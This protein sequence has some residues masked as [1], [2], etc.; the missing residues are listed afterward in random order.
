MVRAPA[1]E[2][3]EPVPVILSLHRTGTSAAEHEITTR[4]ADRASA[5]GYLVISPD[6]G[7]DSATGVR[8]WNQFAATN[9]PDDDAF[10][11][12]A[13]D[14]VAARHCIDRARVFAAGHSSG[15]ALAGLFACRKTGVLQAVVM[16][17]AIAPAGCK[18]GNMP[19]VLAVVGDADPLV[20][21]DGGVAKASGLN[22]PPAFAL[23]ETWVTNGGC[24]PGSKVASAP[25]VLVEL[26]EGCRGGGTARFVTL[27]GGTHA[28]PGGTAVR[29]DEGTPSPLTT[30]DATGAALEL[31]GSS[32]R[33]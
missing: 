10:L 3:A 9:L 16:V 6:A 8:S 13:L 4:L 19:S 20:P 29:D 23:F 26:R 33:T 14:D 11:L 21:V 5:A 18:E 25:G 12:A 32:Q 22:I 30:Y 1:T 28:W 24:V 17:G 15:A 7:I 31:F 27:V 2:G